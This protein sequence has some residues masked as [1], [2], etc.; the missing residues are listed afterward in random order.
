MLATPEYCGMMARYNT[1][2]NTQV[3]AACERLT[4]AQLRADKGAFFG[5]IMNTLNHLLWGDQAWMS[6][7]D[8]GEKPEGGIAE[9]VGLYPTLAVWGVERFRMDTRIQQWADTLNQDDLARDLSWFSGAANRDV[10]APMA[11]CV[12]HMFNHQTHHRGQ[13]HA[14]LTEAG[15]N[16]GDTD[17]FMMP[18]GI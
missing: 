8:D 16:P 17:L 14:M 4:E 5:S 10:T 15:Q 12:V 6:R 11:M 2:Q 3:K 9:S 18:G 7:F 13:I 1:W